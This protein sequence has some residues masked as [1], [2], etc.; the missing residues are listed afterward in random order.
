[1]R[2]CLRSD[3]VVALTV[4]SALKSSGVA[5]T[6]TAQEYALD[7]GEGVFELA[8]IQHL[9]GVSNATADALSRR[10]DPAYADGWVVTCFLANGRCWVPPARTIGWC[11]TLTAPG[12]ASNVV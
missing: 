8:L 3:H 6:L 2:L 10:T 1:M 11:K 12:A 5:G 9:P 4:Y 7:V